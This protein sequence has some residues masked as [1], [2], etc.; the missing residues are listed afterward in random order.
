[1]VRSPGQLAKAEGEGWTMLNRRS[2]IQQLDVIRSERNASLAR[3]QGV[4]PQSDQ[5]RIRLVDLA[6]N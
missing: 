4:I 5:G 1:M 6:M 3:N 2:S